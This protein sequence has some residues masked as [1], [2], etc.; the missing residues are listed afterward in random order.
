MSF[1]IETVFVTEDAGNLTAHAEHHHTEGLE[2]LGTGCYAKVYGSAETP[3]AVKIFRA[4]DAGYLAYIKTIAELGGNKY[5]PRIMNVIHYRY[6]DEWHE[7][8]PNRYSRGP[9][10]S[11]H[12]VFVV[13]QERLTKG[14]S[15]KN[16]GEVRKSFAHDKFCLLLSE[17][18]Q[19]ARVGMLDWTKLRPQ[20]R[21][22]IA[23]LQIAMEEGRKYDD[24]LAVDLHS[25]NVM[26]RK[27]CPVVTDPLC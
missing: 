22:L 14:K 15:W 7:A 1:E 25:G 18:L 4:S 10:M 8:N 17:Y 12:E 27:G 24:T 6:S 21:D 9:G 11:Y 13:I 2:L 20:H 26:S 5:T 19:D 16:F 23:L 3:Y